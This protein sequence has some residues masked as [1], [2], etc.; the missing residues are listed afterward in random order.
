MNR[1]DWTDYTAAFKPL[2]GTPST[3]DARAIY[4]YERPAYIF[5][6]AFMNGLRAAGLTE[7]EAKDWIA[8]KRARWMLDGEMSDKIEAL[9]YEYAKAHAK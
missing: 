6:S 4:S 2:F 1:E 7:E 3:D 5:W 9:A 8:S